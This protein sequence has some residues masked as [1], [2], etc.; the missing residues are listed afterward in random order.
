MAFFKLSESNI[1]IENGGEIIVQKQYRLAKK[2]DFNKVYRQGKS[3]GNRQFVVYYISNAAVDHFRLGV[4]VSKKIGNAVVRNRIRR[5]L[6]EIV[7][8]HAAHISV[9]SDMILIARKPSVE[10][11]YLEMEKSVL[12][13][14]KKT[15]LYEK[16]MVGISSPG[17]GFC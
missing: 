6:K 16:K 4:S 10:M 12:H 2:E 1:L 11:E 14:L 5:M 17:V 9:H 3:M 15:A 8:H 7:R 13:I